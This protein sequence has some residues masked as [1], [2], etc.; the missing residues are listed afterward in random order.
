[1]SGSGVGGVHDAGGGLLLSASPPDDVMNHLPATLLATALHHQQQQQQEGAGQ[2]SPG[3]PGGDNNNGVAGAGAG[4][5][6]SGEMLRRVIGELRE[7][8]TEASSSAV[9]VRCCVRTLLRWGIW[10][11]VCVW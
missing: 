5:D 1:M 3:S 6:A 8:E 2:A 11:R 4:A 9:K 7:L 10:Y